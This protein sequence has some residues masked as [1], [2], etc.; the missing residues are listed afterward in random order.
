MAV[1]STESPPA[2]AEWVEIKLH[3]SFQPVVF[4]LRPHGRSGLKY[5]RVGGQ[6][7][8]LVSPPA[9]AE[10]VEIG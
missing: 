6:L 8:L 5:G 7:A 1:I 10:W 9:R 3:P 4:S 2:R